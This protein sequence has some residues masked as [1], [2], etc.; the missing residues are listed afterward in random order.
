MVPGS[1]SAC[2]AP[3]VRNMVV[4]TRRDLRR[5]LRFQFSEKTVRI[6][7]QQHCTRWTQYPKSA[8]IMGYALFHCRDVI[9]GKRSKD[10]CYLQERRGVQSLRSTFPR[11]H[12][13]RVSSLIAWLQRCSDVLSRLCVLSV[14]YAS[15]YSSLPYN[16]EDRVLVTTGLPAVLA[17]ERCACLL[18]GGRSTFQGDVGA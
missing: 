18:P 7:E 14:N 12:W 6:S 3:A 10:C 16:S 1:E 17:H 13:C 4:Q 9:A 8:R 15:Y 11:V 2:R 5:S